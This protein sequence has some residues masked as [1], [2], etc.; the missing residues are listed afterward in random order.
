MRGWEGATVHVL[1]QSLQ[2]GSLVF[3]VLPLIRDASGGVRG[4]GLREHTA[5]FI[6]SARLNGMRLRFDLEALLGAIGTVV[7]ANPGC[8]TVKLS[9][10]YPG[11][12]LDVLPVDAEA[13]VAIAAFAGA[14][15]MPG[16]ERARKPARLQ[17]AA[18]PKLKPVSS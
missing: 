6:N 1:S 7:R 13:D 18:S 15:L 11:V 9:A 12:S 17:L 3:D 16:M 5:R 2:R 8:D 14:D 10:Y 4:L